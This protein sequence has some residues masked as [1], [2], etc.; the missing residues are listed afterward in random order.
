MKFKERKV[1]TLV[2][3]ATKIRKGCSG[4]KVAK[5]PDDFRK[6]ICALIAD[7]VSVSELADRLGIHFSTLHGWRAKSKTKPKGK[8]FKA[9]K[10]VES[11]KSKLLV[12]GPVKVFVTT[13][14]GSEVHGL[15]SDEIANLIRR[16]IL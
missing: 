2:C 11:P 8:G 6:R 1:H 12:K 7:G 4:G 16:G 9:L 15:S 3:H 13:S 14:L 5:W 10:V